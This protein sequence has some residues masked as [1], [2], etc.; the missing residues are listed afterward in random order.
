MGDGRVSIEAMSGMGVKV[1]KEERGRE[2]HNNTPL[3]FN[4]EH[5]NATPTARCV[6]FTPRFPN[7]PRTKSMVP[8][9]Y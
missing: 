9:R 7:E 6:S 3:F 4:I 2:A 1:I 5:D 8:P